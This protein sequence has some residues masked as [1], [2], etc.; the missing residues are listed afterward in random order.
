VTTRERPAWRRKQV[1]LNW[2]VEVDWNRDGFGPD[3]DI[4]YWVRSLSYRAKIDGQVASVGVANI[5]LDNREGDFRPESVGSRFGPRMKPR[6][7]VRILDD[8]KPLWTGY[9]ASWE[10][11]N[12]K[13]RGKKACLLV[14]KD[15]MDVLQTHVVSF[16][17]Q[18]N[19][20]SD[21]L[22][23]HIINDALYAPAASQTFAFKTQPAEWDYIVIDGKIFQFKNTF[24]SNPWTE[25]KIGA[26]LYD[27]IDNLLAAYN[28]GPGDG[29]LYRHYSR[30]DT[31]SM[32]PMPSFFST[33]RRANPVRW[34]RLGEVGTSTIVDWG[35]N[36]R[37]ATANFT[38]LGVE[39]AL[40]DDYATAF[41][42]TSGRVS[43]PTTSLFQNASFSF[44]AW[45]QPSFGPPA[46]QAI[47]GAYVAATQGRA[48]YLQVRSDGSLYFSNY[49]TDNYQTAA[50]L[51]PF[52]GTP[53]HVA[54]TYNHHTMQRRL[55]VNG[56]QVAQWTA[57]G[58]FTEAA[59][60]LYIGAD[61][62]VAHF[63][64]GTL[65]E[66]AIYDTTLTHEQV[67]AH[68]AAGDKQFSVITADSPRR[69]YRLNEGVMPTAVDVGSDASNGT[70][71]GTVALKTA[72]LV[73]ALHGDPDKSMG[74]D[75]ISYTVTAP[76]LD[77]ANRDFWVHAWVYPY[78][79]G[80]PA[81]QVFFSAYTANA[82]RSHLHMRV[83]NTGALTIDFYNDGITLP[84]GTVRIGT[85]TQVV[86]K[87][88]Y[89]TNTTTI[90]INGKVAWTGSIGPFIAAAPT[91]YFG[92][93]GSG[94][95]VWNGAIDEVMIGWGDIS[96]QMVRDLYDARSVAP[97]VVVTARVRGAVGNNYLNAVSNPASIAIS[98][99]GYLQGGVDYPSNA[100]IEAGK[101]TFDIAGDQWNSET[102]NAMTCIQDV[103]DSERSFFWVGRGGEPIYKNRDWL[104]KRTVAAPVVRF[105]GEPK[106]TSANNSE[107]V[108][109]IV[110][111]TVTP[112]ETLTS[113]VVAKS[114]STITAEGT[115]QK[116]P[117]GSWTRKASTDEKQPNVTTV[118]L[119]YVDP[120]TGK[121]SGAKNLTLPPAPNT[122]YTAWDF[123]DRT[124]FNYTNSG[125]LTFGV[126]PKTTG[127]EIDIHN[128]A[129]G[130]LYIF[131][132]QIRG[133][134][135]VAYNPVTKEARYEPGISLYG[136]RTL[137][138]N[139]P[140]TSSEALASAIA[141][142]LL[143]QYKEPK[144]RI[145]KVEVGQ[146]RETIDGISLMNVNI[147][148]VVYLTDEV[149]NTTNQKYL[150][151]G[152]EVSMEPGDDGSGNVAT[153][154]D[155]LRLDDVTYGII[156]DVSYGRLD[157]SM[158][159]SI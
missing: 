117:D 73:P 68:F 41:D 39:G 49:G 77:L 128:A 101:D 105:N 54:F 58:H 140:L 108:Y 145:N 25:V 7:P 144:E 126:I 151:T 60:V 36:K 24:T 75:G 110:K 61:E 84:A 146:E 81:T 35:T 131:D 135:I 29:T 79:A 102:T 69:Y 64:K 71:Q 42:G 12:A 38:P 51:I 122:D 23:R 94:G 124:G 17:I 19:Q 32:A 1:R 86:V 118:T 158:R 74:F 83:A 137:S 116:N 31:Q 89:A 65:D 47:F 15:F 22:I 34:Y 143:S 44:E 97:G 120:G 141:H 112:R 121:I 99:G 5:T 37:N 115:S 156:D 4:T 16:P 40:I 20:R 133:Q 59:P 109:N 67:A 78:L 139:L 11:D 138:V 132:F 33:A 8:G 88:R 87:Y 119:Q 95:E 9:T 100:S 159:L 92:R 70:Y 111:V 3:D 62:N 106:L 130:P 80:L 18:E 134:A 103:C 56:A 90:Y 45:I 154:F 13:Y 21:Q 57:L 91:L 127:I 93:F 82:T 129:I 10:M 96:D 114:E 2:K 72:G 6:L 76:P 142:Y 27:T 125:Y 113:G 149:M 104:F 155:V 28:G 52:T 66:V 26:N 46:A 43:I 98:G 157:I 147:G 152:Y 153:S 48:M 148:D 85:W 107:E 50:G 14:C 53:T 150:I 136:S 63:F 123:P 30:P 55:Y